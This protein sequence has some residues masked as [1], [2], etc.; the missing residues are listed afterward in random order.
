MRWVRGVYIGAEGSP[1]RDPGGIVP[2]R[3]SE[4]QS[5]A[6]PLPSGVKN[7]GK[8]VWSV[9]GSDRGDVVRR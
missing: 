4:A 2:V 5:S 3:A 1:H 6:Q 8:P 9:P 7:L